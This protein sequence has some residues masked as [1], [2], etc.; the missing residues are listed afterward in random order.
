VKPAP[1]DY[2]APATVAETVGLLAGLG[3]EAK[4]LAGGQ[5]L[6]PML[7]LRLARPEHIVDLNRVSELF[8]VEH[9]DGVLTVGAMVR[10]ATAARHPEIVA[11]APLLA[12]AAPYIGHF[13]IRN[14]GTVGGSLVHADPAAEHPAVAV[15]LD[16]EMEA[17]GP[18]GARRIPAAEFFESTFMTTLAPDEVLVAIRY[19]DWGPG[20]GFA[21]EE[22]A[23]R[24]GDF[25]LA[26]VG[27]GVQVADGAITRSAVAM[28]GVAGTPVR[29]GAAENALTGA[30]VQGLAIADI[31]RDAVAMLQPPTDV[32][33]GGDYR[34]QIAAMLVTR[35][36][37]RAI[38]EASGD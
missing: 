4:L 32:H 16:A 21:V 11:A 17:I 25:A 29:L 30:H 27:C 20:S 33:A 2:H 12:R 34:K 28:L 18:S 19:P 15:A 31:A 35:A 5:S 23:R 36:L 24:S 8:R 38:E 22:V 10:H 13:Q 3:D 6:V 14:R 7:A 1:F 9:A 26:G 37:T